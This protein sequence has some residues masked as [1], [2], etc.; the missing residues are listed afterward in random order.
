[1]Y[2]Y[3]EEMFGSPVAF[4]FSKDS[5]N[6]AF[7]RFDDTNVSEYSWPLY[8]EPGV[9]ETVCFIIINI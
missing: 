2:R 7:V 6:L 9:K 1:M 3:L 8:G 4:W 5:S